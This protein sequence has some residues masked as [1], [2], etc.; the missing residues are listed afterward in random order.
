MV[1]NFRDMLEKNW[2]A[3]KFLCVGLDP[4]FEKVP[5]HL[6]R[7]GIH[8]ALLA[9]N[10]GI[11]D[12]TADIAGSYKPNTAFYEA[13][14]DIG[15]E[16]L[17]ETIQYIRENAPDAPVIADA[18]RGD[19]GNSNNGYVDAIFKH[20]QA[21]AI[22]VHPYL[23]AEALKPFL[24]QSDK[25]VIVLCRTSNP[26]AREVQ[27]LL[28]GDIPLYQAVARMVADSWNAN[29]NCALVVGAT[30]PNELALVRSIAPDLPILIPGVGAQ[31][32]DV[33]KTIENGRDARG[34]GMI[35][36]SSRAIMYAS[37]GTDFEEAAHRAAYALDS[38]I[39]EAAVR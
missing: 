22:T 27:D 5:E 36:A 2:A 8:D 32:G 16:V 37:N 31:G 39:R 30:Y 34:C 11:I 25:G 12:A 10:R 7:H 19:I 3:G 15:W 21:D 38:A 6:K 17:R 28:V 24:E 4:D 23:G 9:F 29:G 1:R 35:I 14:G 33:K 26:G 18:K 13:Y 20:L